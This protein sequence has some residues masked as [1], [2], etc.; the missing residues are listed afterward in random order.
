MKKV[1]LVLLVLVFA[2]CSSLTRKERSVAYGSAIGGGLGAIVGSQAGSAGAGMVIG[3]VAGAGAGALIGH[4]LQTQEDTINMQA[5][6]VARQNKTIS[7]QQSEINE[8]RNVTNDNLTYS[9]RRTTRSSVM[10]KDI[11]ASQESNIEEVNITEQMNQVSPEFADKVNTGMAAY[12]WNSKQEETQFSSQECLDA[13]SEAKQAGNTE[14]V[15]EKLYHYRRALRLCP[16][17]P[18][19]H[20][21]LGEVYIGMDRFDDAKYEFKEALR[22]DSSYGKALTNLENLAS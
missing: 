21:A 19:F 16:E 2:S 18:E 17:N 3:S 22:L 12:D 8:L 11:I 6:T 10:E 5:E 4:E 14:E 9:N 1:I 13:S 20:N 7:A 15:A